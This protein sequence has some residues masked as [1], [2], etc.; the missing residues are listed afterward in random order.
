MVLGTQTDD[1]QKCEIFCGDAH[2]LKPELN[3]EIEEVDARLIP[4]R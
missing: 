4:H 2:S 3:S 1:L